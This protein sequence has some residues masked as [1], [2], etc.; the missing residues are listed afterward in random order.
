[1]RFENTASSSVVTLITA[2]AL[3]SCAVSEHHYVCSPL[4]Q[5]ISGVGQPGSAS[6]NTE[7]EMLLTPTSLRIASRTY[8]FF[9][10]QARVRI[11]SHKDS[12][13]T[14][15]FD[16]FSNRLTVENMT[17]QCRRLENL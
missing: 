12:G 14:A 16:P 7:E 15:V 10:E 2:I 11:Y 13:S 9:E 4:P 17:M 5:Q 6:I 1:M 3:A 8:G